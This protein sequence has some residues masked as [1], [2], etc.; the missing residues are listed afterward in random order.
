MKYWI[1]T[2]SKDHVM[3]GKEESF[4][5]AGHGKKNSTHEITTR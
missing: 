4:V 3:V 2:V 1:N 5:Q